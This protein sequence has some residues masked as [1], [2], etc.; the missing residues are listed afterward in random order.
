LLRSIQKIKKNTKKEKS[1]QDGCS[2]IHP[3]FQLLRRLRKEDFLS[4]ACYLKET[5]SQKKKERGRG[6][7]GIQLNGRACLA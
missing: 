7:L 3:Y 5:L 2:G 4:P 1:I 6:Y